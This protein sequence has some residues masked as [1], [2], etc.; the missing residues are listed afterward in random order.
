MAGGSNT[1]DGVQNDRAGLII[2]G[3][4]SNVTDFNNPRYDKSIRWNYGDSGVEG[5]LT[6]NGASNEAYWDV[7]GGSLR[8]TGVKD[9]ASN[10]EIGFGMR[11][12][13]KDELEMVRHW[14]DGNGSNQITRFVRFGRK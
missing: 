7:R 12:N 3:F 4:P 1:V 5:L 6:S 2:A 13:D 14:V 10:E 11:I 9:N 8:L